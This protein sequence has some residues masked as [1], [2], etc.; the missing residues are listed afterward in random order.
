MAS[1]T[2]WTWV[3]V[4]SG[5][6]WWTGRPG[7]LQFMGL[8][9]VRHDWATE[10]TWCFILGFPDSSAGK[11]TTCRVGHPGLTSGW[12]RSPEWIGYPFQYSWT[13][14]VTQMVKKPPALQE[15]CIW[16]LGW[17]FPLEEG[18]ATHSCTLAWRITMDREAWWPTV[19]WVSKSQ[20]RLTKHSTWFTS[21][22]HYPCIRVIA[23]HFSC[24][25]FKTIKKMLLC[26]L[27]A[28]LSP[29]SGT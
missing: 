9:R 27:S 7:V 19:H 23:C 16:F 10:L 2:W 11:D 4:N 25:P 29:Q 1:P 3:W 26:V 17:E 14:Q 13:F 6:W 18:M 8:Q 24:Y 22:Q 28:I 15:T 21:T 20:T 5:S 12:G